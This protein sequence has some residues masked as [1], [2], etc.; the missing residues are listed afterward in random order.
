MFPVVFIV[1]V[2][3]VRVGRIRD[4][5][6]IPFELR[7]SGWTED[8]AM[9]GTSV[10]EH[11]ELVAF[12]DLLTV[13]NC[14]LASGYLRHAYSNEAHQTDILVISFDKDNS[15]S[16]HLGD[17]W[18]RQVRCRWIQVRRRTEG[19]IRARHDEGL[20][21]RTVD[22][23]VPTMVASSAEEGL[24]DA[25]SVPELVF[26]FGVVVDNVVSGVRLTFDPELGSRLDIQP[27]SVQV[28]LACSNND[29]V[30]GE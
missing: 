13:V 27:N 28:R 5:F 29:F 7:R 2:R 20:N 18:L 19:E 17:V 25:A 23:T 10:M 6:R 16:S 30:V 3:I 24:K 9:A 14:D 1:F 11:S 12:L 22:G 26:P 15:P 8:E 21:N 4:V